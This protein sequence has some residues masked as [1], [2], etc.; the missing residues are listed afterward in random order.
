[1]STIVI[2][3]AFPLMEDV[4]DDLPVFAYN[5]TPLKH[6]LD[7]KIDLVEQQG[8][9]SDLII[10]DYC[11]SSLLQIPTMMH[12]DHLSFQLVAWKQ[13]FAKLFVKPHYKSFY[14]IIWFALEK[15]MQ[16]ERRKKNTLWQL[17][18]SALEDVA[19]LSIPKMLGK[20]KVTREDKME[21]WLCDVSAGLHFLSG[22]KEQVLALDELVSETTGNVKQTLANMKEAHKTY[23]GWMSTP[24]GVKRE[25][26]FASMYSM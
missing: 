19:P 20:L 10:F 2:R 18:Q 26:G 3:K 25:K 12:P 5:Y 17:L 14:A 24:D 1:M 9:F 8:L 13:A 7:T 15:L 22:G 4:V 23:E 21:E 11:L 6:F 16:D